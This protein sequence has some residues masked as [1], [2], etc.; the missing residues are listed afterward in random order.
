VQVPA[1]TSNLGPGFDVLG[2]ALKLYNEVEL[3]FDPKAPAAL[4]L[5][6]EGEGAESIPADERNV[7][8]QCVRK[9]AGAR[10]PRG[11]YEVRFVNRIPLA[12]G[13]GSSAAARLSGVLTAQ[14]L[15]G[16]T[17]VQSVLDRA[18]ALEGHPDN[19]VPQM[20]GGL[21]VSWMEGGRVR[22]LKAAVPQ[23]LSAVV[24]VPEFELL[25]SKARAAIPKTISHADAVHNVSR[26]ALLLGALA[27][28]DYSV[29]K[30][31]MQDRL[32]QI[33]RKKLVP[34]FD[35]VVGNGLRAGALGVALSGAGPSMFAFAPARR[36]A[37]VGRA[38]EK[39]FSKAGK[40]S[41]SL[42]LEFDLRGARVEARAS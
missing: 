36:A 31:A 17:D 8:W 14:A 33:Y 40:K 3:R 5:S 32:H 6:V 10:L 37:A 25:T 26:V 4:D 42:V 2:L 21:C 12:R 41:R 30:T 39:G 35:A 20:V 34:G 1:S 22:Y 27:A 23:G 38:M 24:C 15:L 29:L 19:V 9:T 13:L 16:K 18:T 11:R 7:I 28:K